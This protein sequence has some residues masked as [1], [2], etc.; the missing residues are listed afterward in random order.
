MTL[1][2]GRALPRGLY[3]VS[4][5]RA[6]DQAAAER[7]GLPGAVLMERAGRAAWQLLRMLWPRAARVAVLC[8][9]GNNGG[10]GLVVARLAHAAG[11]DVRVLCPAT[12]PGRGAAAG[13]AAKRLAAAGLATQPYTHAALADR[14]VL[15]DALLGTGLQSAAHGALLDALKALAARPADVL[16][17][18]VP[19][20]LDAATGHVAG[21]AVCARATLS[22]I[23]LK[24]GLLSGA[25]PDC[26]GQLYA[27]GL[28][29]PA[30]AYPPE[31]AALRLDAALL[32]DALPA[33]KRGAHKGDCG[34]VL[35]VGGEHGYAGAARLA[36][37][38]AA[39]AG[40]GLVSVATRSAHCCAYPELMIHAVDASESLA[41]LMRR[42]TVL[43]VGPGLGQGAWGGALLGRCLESRLPAVVD[44]DGLNLLAAQPQQRREA[45]WILTPH[46]GE[47]ARLLGCTSAE[48]QADRYTAARRLRET[49]GAVIVLKGAGTVIADEQGL[50]VVHGGNPGMASGG[51]GDVL[52][53]VI[54]GL[55]AQGRPAAQAARIGACLHAAAGD[56]AARTGGE[57]GLLAGDLL[58]WV[59]HLA[60]PVP[61]PGI[62]VCSA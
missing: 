47:A 41:P 23:A 7:C 6:I 16:A 62:G 40:A 31:P 28:G 26:C 39:R 11:L 35:V 21:S 13:A 9:P 30:A 8:G 52:T 1:L 17:L 49:Y 43:A 22:F 25:G 58:P 2:A 5:C 42:A 27:A 14:E 15:V 36:S 45:P 53:G 3:G 37:L 54:A 46:P 44:A 50:A 32:E 19:S 20:G 29:V 33:R 61:A 4:A 24:T 12:P 57:R 59:R 10:D 55:W 34:H 56:A 38:A 60:N 51:M 48:V 18:D